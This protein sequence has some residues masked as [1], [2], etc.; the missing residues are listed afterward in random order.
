[1]TTLK[2]AMV[3]ICSGLGLYWLAS[4][5]WFAHA[6]D[7]SHAAYSTGMAC[8]MELLSQYWGRERAS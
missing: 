6:A 2:L 1:M 7:Y 5:L 8:Y 3:P 4:A